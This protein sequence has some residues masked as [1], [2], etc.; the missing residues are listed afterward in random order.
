MSLKVASICH[1]PEHAVLWYTI[2]TQE[3]GSGDL[4]MAFPTTTAFTQ[5][6]KELLEVVRKLLRLANPLLHLGAG[7]MTTG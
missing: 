4:R 7:K 3:H 1:S 2:V 6:V 5:Q